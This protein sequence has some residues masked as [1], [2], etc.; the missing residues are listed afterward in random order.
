M[1]SNVF[2]FYNLY[3]FRLATIVEMKID[4]IEIDEKMFLLLTL[5][6]EK[7]NFYLLSFRANRIKI[8]SIMRENTIE[9]DL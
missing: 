7:R 1:I 2:D 5:F 3:E 8:D 6:Y 9:F 4:E